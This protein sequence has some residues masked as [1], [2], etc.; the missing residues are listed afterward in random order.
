VSAAEE[1]VPDVYEFDRERHQFK[2]HGRRVFS[3]TQA[4]R[5]S[6]L[7][8][9]FCSR[10][11]LEAARQ[12]GQDV[13]MVVADMDKHP[14]T[15]AE[16]YWESDDR[17]TG[18]GRAWAAFKREYGFVHDASEQ[19]VFNLVYQYGGIFDKRGWIFAG[20]PRQR[21][22]VV[23]IKSGAAAPWHAE[24]LAG[25]ALALCP[26]TEALLDLDRLAVY[27]RPDGRFTVRQFS[28]HKDVHCFL[29]ALTVARLRSERGLVRP[30][31]GFDEIF[32]G[33]ID[34][35]KFPGIHF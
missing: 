21:N 14:F 15:E 28:D 8:R 31:V 22:V 34:R 4:L 29:A 13:H 9:F 18:Y 12:R 35:S 33:E 26:K 30:D 27:L 10:P 16:R 24:Q 2:I 17:L 19:Q 5:E 1:E 3:V 20:T 11:V 23:E 7:V 6:G 32:T 25:Y